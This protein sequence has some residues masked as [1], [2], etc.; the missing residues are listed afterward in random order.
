MRGSRVFTLIELF[1]FM[2]II[3]VLVAILLPAVQQA[4]EAAR[5]AQCKC[6]L[7]QIGLAVAKYES[8][9]T[10]L[11]PGRIR[12]HVDKLQL[13]FSVHAHLLPH[14]DQANIY[15]S[16]NF[17]AGAD[18]GPENSA[19]RQIMLPIF[20]C[21]SDRQV[22]IQGADAVHNYVIETGTVY[23]VVK[24]DGIFFGNSNLRIRE[25]TYGCFH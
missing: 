11:P 14:L 12:S 23:G 22:P 20:Q 8:A 6:N 1:V 4:G 19:P 21:P 16:L 9:L 13:C 3:A 7:K 2:A 17:G 18:T 24:T 25:M 5:R 10:V 15:D